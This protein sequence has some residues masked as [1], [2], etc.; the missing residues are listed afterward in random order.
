MTD[1]GRSNLPALD[2]LFVAIDAVSVADVTWE[3]VAYGV[4]TAPARLLQLPLAFLGGAAGMARRWESGDGG[5]DVAVLPLRD[6]VVTTARAAQESG[7]KVFVIDAGANPVA[8]RLARRLGFDGVQTPDNARAMA[9]GKRT[10]YIAGMNADAELARGAAAVWTTAGGAARTSASF[11]GTLGAPASSLRAIVKA[12]RPHQY[13]K[14]ILL[15]APP[16]MA[17]R[18]REPG[19]WL[20]AVIA[21]ACLSLAASGVYVTN[22]LLDVESDRRHPTKKRRPFAAGHLSVPAGLVL[23]PGLFIAAIVIAWLTLPLPFLGLL[24]SYM[25]I[26]T[27][28]SIR[29]KRTMSLDVLVLASLYTLRIVA[30]GAATQIEVSPWLLAFSTFFF[31]SLAVL[32]RYTELDRLRAAGAPMGSTRRGYKPVDM[33]I[34]RSVG[35]T[36]GYLAVLVFVLYINSEHM[37]LLYRHPT[38]LWLIAPLLLYWIT[39]IWILAQRDQVDDD[40][41]V[42]AGK[43]GVSY[44]VGLLV[45]LLAILAA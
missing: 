36:S 7:A 30:G 41:I 4:R 28:Y 10:G 27:S 1:A 37:T 35:P 42:F 8:Q 25:V 15:F 33:E 9:A 29:W 22:D 11:K 3:S 23:G 6:D 44:L 31:L 40:P 20:A 14:N 39:R 21:F 12:L 45:L 16:L 32:K 18:I 38:M 19:I 24:V 17:H 13:V 43:D 26:S 2:L 5:V 34:L